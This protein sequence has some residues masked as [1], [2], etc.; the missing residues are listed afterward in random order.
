MP[1]YQT[2]CPVYEVPP[3]PLTPDPRILVLETWHQCNYIS[4][5]Y[6]A[7]ASYTGHF[8]RYTGSGVG[9]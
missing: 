9:E 4:P 2:K 8:V 3:E 5:V 6:E 1:V 7:K